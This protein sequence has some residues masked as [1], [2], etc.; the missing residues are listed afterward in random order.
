MISTS[1]TVRVRDHD[2]ADLAAKLEDLRLTLDQADFS[3]GVFYQLDQIRHVLRDLFL[4]PDPA[5]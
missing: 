5:R 4:G 2:A 3:F 1:A